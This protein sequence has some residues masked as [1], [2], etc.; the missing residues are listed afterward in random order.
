MYYKE[1]LDQEKQL[2]TLIQLKIKID[3]GYQGL[4]L[5]PEIG[6]TSEFEEKFIDFFGFCTCNLAFWNIKKKE[7]NYLEWVANG[8]IKVVIGARSALFLPFKK[9]RNNNRR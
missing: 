8:K 9:F 5:L 2:Y 6:L 1:Q 4:I 7:K 3:Q